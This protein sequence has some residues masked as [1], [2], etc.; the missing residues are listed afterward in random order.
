MNRTHSVVQFANQ[1][2]DRESPAQSA[3][4][5]QL[6]ELLLFLSL[7]LGV[8]RIADSECLTEDSSTEQG[9]QLQD[10]LFQVIGKQTE[11]GG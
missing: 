10:E 9:A 5:L 8:A 1:V 6:A 11:K 3:R 4:M 7:L 2:R